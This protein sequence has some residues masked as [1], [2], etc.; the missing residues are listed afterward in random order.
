MILNNNCKHIN[1]VESV[2]IGLDFF[3]IPT[4][5]DSNAVCL[6]IEMKR[7]CLFNDLHLTQATR[8]LSCVI[9]MVFEKCIYRPRA[10]CGTTSLIFKN[11][12]DNCIIMLWSCDL[13]WSH[14]DTLWC[15]SF[16]CFQVENFSHNS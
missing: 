10:S 4:L 16:Y 5:C 3:V 11:D 9:F 15:L 6:V 14:F 13:R 7:N 1:Y 2:L 12:V 8:E